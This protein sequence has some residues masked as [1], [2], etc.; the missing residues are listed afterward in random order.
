V[1]ASFF[2]LGRLFLAKESLATRGRGM[3]ERNDGEKDALSVLTR[4]EATEWK[5]RIE[6]VAWS[7]LRGEEE[8]GAL[9]KLRR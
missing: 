8:E 7:K 3:R 5:E 1:K 6:R 2:T 4:V 9:G